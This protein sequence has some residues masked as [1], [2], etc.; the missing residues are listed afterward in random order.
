MEVGRLRKVW[1]EGSWNEWCV[2]FDDQRFGW[3][4]EAQGDWAV[5]FE[6][7]TSV[8]Q[9]VPPADQAG[10]VAPGTRWSLDGRAFVVTDV[11]QVTCEGAEGELAEV[12]RPGEKALCIDL[13]GEGAGFAT[14]EFRQRAVKTYVGRFVDFD[15]CRFANLRQIAGWGAGS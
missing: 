6:T 5:T 2:L 12:Y 14:V 7:P 8:L 9:G 4:G 15:E 11:K 13:R 1:E 10:R 3:L